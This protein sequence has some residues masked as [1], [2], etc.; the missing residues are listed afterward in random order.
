MI[1]YL[2][3]SSLRES[4]ERGFR[5]MAEPLIGRPIFRQLGVGGRVG[6]V[7]LSSGRVVA[8][9]FRSGAPTFFRSMG[10][11]CMRGFRCG[12]GWWG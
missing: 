4:L 1:R 5:G 8:R 3:M 9:L 7:S 10:W 12:G 2:G 11:E 6:G